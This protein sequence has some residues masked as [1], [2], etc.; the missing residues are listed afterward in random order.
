VVRRKLRDRNIQ[1]VIFNIIGRTIFGAME[2]A[3][4]IDVSPF[5]FSLCSLLLG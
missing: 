2:W 1:I 4:A 3:H 5:G